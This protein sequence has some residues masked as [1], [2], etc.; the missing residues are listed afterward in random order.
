MLDGD[1][2]SFYHIACVISFKGAIEIQQSLEFFQ[3]KAQKVKKNW[4]KTIL[5]TEFSCQF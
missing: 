5:R 1:T 3:Y 4:L 2:L